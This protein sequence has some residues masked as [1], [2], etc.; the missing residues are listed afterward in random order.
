[1]YVTYALIE[2]VTVFQI[3]KH[4]TVDVWQPIESIALSC[5]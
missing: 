4:Y 3:K 5:R 1:M 2:D